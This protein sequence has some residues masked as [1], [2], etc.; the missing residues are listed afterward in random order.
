MGIRCSCWAPSPTSFISEWLTLRAQLGMSGSVLFSLD[1]GGRGYFQNKLFNAASAAE[2][3]H[4]VRST[5]ATASL[6]GKSTRH[7][8][9]GDLGQHR[10]ERL[11]RLVCLVQC[12]RHGWSDT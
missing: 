9:S 7:R 1:Y 10:L 5:L 4:E 6:S 11:Q 3:F 12:H 2:G 8:L